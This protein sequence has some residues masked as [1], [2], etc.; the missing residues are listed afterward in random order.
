MRMGK[1][2]ILLL[3]LLTIPFITPTVSAQD[4]EEAAIYKVTATYKLTNRSSGSALN[5]EALISLFDNFSGWVDQRVLGE[6]IEVDGVQI[7]PKIQRGKENRWIRVSIGDVPGWSTKTISV[8]QTLKVGVGPRIDQRMVGEDFPPEVQKY[9]LAV[10][11]LFESDDDEIR[12]FADRVVGQERNPYSKAKR[13]LDAVKGHLTY[14]RQHVEHSA[15]WAY[16]SGVGD[17]TE[18]SNLYIALAR[19]SG[20]PAKAIT[21]VVYEDGRSDE[22]VWVLIYLPNV[23]WV[24]LDPQ[25]PCSLGKIGYTHIVGATTCGENVVVNGEIRWPGPPHISYWWSPAW[26][27]LDYEVPPLR[28]EPEVFVDLKVASVGVRDRIW[29]FSISVRN[30]GAATIENIRVELQADNDYFEVSPP[31]SIEMLVAGG[32]KLVNFDVYVKG[33]TENS[34]IRAVAT[35]D[36]PYGSFLAR[37]DDLLVS[38]TIIELPHET[39][40]FLSLVMI[41]SLVVLV[42]VALAQR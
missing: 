10:P 9:T 22:H 17:C 30:Y 3:A 13:I 5:V 20:I 16:H 11:G 34:P 23:G 41:V 14:A 28:V 8:V 1:F 38:P 40:L 36:T 37:S 24:A 42:A 7:L 15:L 27:T 35:Y 18:Y 25:R 2:S 29:G 32:Y 12:A 31:Q 6:R 21:G 26:V 19:A 39:M 33:T 4:L